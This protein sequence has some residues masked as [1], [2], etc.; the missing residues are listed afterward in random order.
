MRIYA[1]AFL[2][3]ALCSACARTDGPPTDEILAGLGPH[4]R[5]VTTTSREAQA[6]FDRGLAYLY[7]FNQDEAIASFKKA[8]LLDPKCAMAYWGIAYANGPHINNPA[9]TDDRSK[10]AYEALAQAQQ[11]VATGSAV[12]KALVA[13]LGKRY[14]LPEPEDRSSLDVAYAE[15]M[16][17]VHATFPEDA[18]VAALT[19]EALMDIHPWDLYEHDGTAKPWTGEIVAI[20]ETTLARAPDHPLGNHLYIHAVEA[21]S[22]AGRADAAADV[23]RDLMP[24]LGHMDHMPSHIDVRRGRWEAAIAANTKAIAAD[25]AY[26][27]ANP[28]Q[29]FY[30]LYMAHNSHMRAYAAMMA[31]QSQLALSTIRDMV[32]VIPTDWLKENASWADGFIAMPYEVEMRFGRW[33]EILAEPEP[34]DYLPLTRA[35]RHYAR[36]VAY[37][38][39]G[40]VAEAQA[41]QRAFAEAKTKVD[42]AA[43]FGNNSAG[44]ILALAGA[45]L[46][47]EVLYRAGKQG[48]GFKALYQAVRL[49]DAL[50]YDEPPSWIQ[51][52]RHA[53][54][55]ALLQS[56][57]YAEAEEVYR[58]DLEEFENNGWALYGLGRTLRLQKKDA[59]AAEVEARFSEEWKDADIKIASSCFCQS[60]V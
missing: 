34:A 30:R 39:Q 21:S 51:P 55:A 14:A 22:D 46:D 4:R 57:R 58:A 11:A 23:L 12:E 38:A 19:A 36:G 5:A 1:S 53:L 37:A 35:L 43:S 8:A 49:E 9:M 6:D 59:E 2:L 50:R 29:G 13:A 25:R 18:D 45:L 16:R 7:G 48:A 32:A 60:G 3:L 41:E 40:K 28:K 47:G 31:G 10:A 20:L 15:A 52:V 56:G 17:G 26:R 33:D 27:E 44:D 54:G 24:A 42:P